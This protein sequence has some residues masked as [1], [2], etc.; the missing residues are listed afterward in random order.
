MFG[1]NDL[2][3]EYNDVYGAPQQTG[4]AIKEL[5]TADGTQ[6]RHIYRFSKFHD[7]VGYQGVGISFGGNPTS[8]SYYMYLYGNLISKN[9]TLGVMPHRE[10]SHIY[11]WSNIISDN[12]Q[13]GVSV[14]GD[15][16]SGS[17]LSFTNNTVVRNGTESD[18][19]PNQLNRGGISTY[20]GSSH[21][22]KNNLFYN[23]RVAGALGLYNQI[24]DTSSVALEHN[25]LFHSSA[26]A[27]WYYDGGIRSLGDM[28]NIYGRE[29]DNPDGVVDEDLGA[30]FTDPNGTD[31]IYG[32]EDD[33]YTL[34][35]D[36]LTNGAD[37][38]PDDDCIPQAVDL[39]GGDAWM[40]TNSSYGRYIE[41]CLGYGLD[42]ETTDWTTTP[43]TVGTKQRGVDS[44]IEW[45]RGAYV[46]ITEEEDIPTTE[47]VSI[48]Q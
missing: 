40:E 29:D 8:G 20:W 21:E 1:C 48:G 30:I 10:F 24:F 43:P 41:V 9:Y 45:E 19:D 7:N 5:G 39:S 23:N 46:W 35:A 27:T 31:N 26:T 4:W 13:S 2:L 18:P 6:N 28:Q 34:N 22:I 12:G 47:G 38:D 17:Y 11:L 42:P 25:T 14:W 36:T 16:G 15:E 3:F 32:T 37:L 33:D 44:G